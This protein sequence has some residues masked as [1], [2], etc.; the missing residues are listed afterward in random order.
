M[1]KKNIMIVA[2]MFT[3]LLQ[4]MEEDLKIVSFVVD[5]TTVQLVKGSLD[6][7]DGY[8]SVMVVGRKAQQKLQRPDFSGNEYLG[9][10][11]EVK[12]NVLYVKNR[13]ADSASDDDGYKPFGTRNRKLWKD[14][15]C[16]PLQR[17][18]ILTIVEPHIKIFY[19]ADTGKSVY[20][21]FVEKKHSARDNYYFDNSYYG[22]KAIDEAKEDLAMCYHKALAVASKKIGD[23]RDKKVALSALSTEVG[24]PRAEAAP[25]AV[26]SVVEFIK[27]NRGL[28][29]LVQLYVKKRSEFTVYETLLRNSLAAEQR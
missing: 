12:D 28:Y 14:A 2:C 11:C 23:M 27:N 20:S 10:L 17:T 5:K 26:K 24:F 21:Y 25:V 19:C 9:G 7:A 29:S 13:D 3:A 22:N 1:M 6:N 15:Q 8:V 16:K 18:N 4:G